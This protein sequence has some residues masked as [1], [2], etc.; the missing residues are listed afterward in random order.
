M[1]GN[2][3]REIALYKSLVRE[4]HEVSFITYGGTSDLKYSS[5]VEGISILCNKEDAP[6]DQ[7]EANLV[8]LHRRELERTAVI[9]TNQSYGGE[10]AVDAALYLDKPLIARCGYMWSFNAG[11]EHGHDS[12]QAKEARRVE[13][14]LFGAAHRIVVTTE[15]MK[16]DVSARIPDASDKTIV[17]PNYVDSEVFRPL[18]LP[19]VARSVLFVGRIAPEKNLESLIQAVEPLDL[20]LTLIGEGKLRPQ[21][22]ERYRRL[23]EKLVWEGNLPGSRLPA[24][25]NQADV[26]V[27]P[28]LYEGH[29]KAMIEA[30]A[31][32]CA[33]L[34]ADSPGIRDIIEHQR[35]GYLCSPDSESIGSALQ[36]L[37]DNSELRKELGRNAREFTLENYSLEKILSMELKLLN[38]VVQ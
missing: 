21:L 16:D 27:M 35:N 9:K 10:L 3:Q 15:T 23:G 36:E 4:G 1:V 34:G 8:K 33:V 38:E 20:R 28:S 13:M 24:L 14:V 7:Y 37:L 32:G 17:I 26:F 22:Q 18:D 25:I 2:L 5:E 11:R 29:P 12:V 6:I 19:K 31:C 30:M